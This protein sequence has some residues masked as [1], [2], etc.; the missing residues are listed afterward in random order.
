MDIHDVARRA[1]V[2]A[3][4]VSQAINRVPT[5][6]EKLAKQLRGDLDNIVLKALR[7]EPEC[8]YASVDQFAEDIRLTQ[9]HLPILARKDS[10]S[11]RAA[12]FIKRHKAG[13]AAAVSIA[14]IL[15]LGLVITMREA[16]K[17]E[18]RF[19]DVRGLANSLIFDVHDS[20]KD[21]PGSTPARKIIV[22]RALQYLNLLAQ[23]SAGDIALQRELATAY[24]KVGKVQGDYLQN[25]LGDTLGAL[26]SYEKALEIR[27]QLD[28]R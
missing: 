2:S 4:T 26:V 8:R 18:R 25:N 13:V 19:N 15:V 23:E 5:A 14:A 10:A 12:K 27:R 1:K 7:K 3:A 28:I 6:P 20:I 22:D 9:A 11:Y 16:R 17:A 24:E 21:L